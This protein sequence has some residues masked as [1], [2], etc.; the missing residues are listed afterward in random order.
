MLQ[1]LKNKLIESEHIA[2][3]KRVSNWKLPPQGFAY[4]KKEIE[5]KEG[6]SKCKL[7]YN[8]YQ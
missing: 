7:L 4:G 2:G 6:A 1:T 8:I 5:D 3:M